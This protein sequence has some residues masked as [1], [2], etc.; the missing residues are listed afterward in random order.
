METDFFILLLNGAEMVETQ[1]LGQAACVD[2]TG[3]GL[4]NAFHHD[5][6]GAIPHRN[7]NAFLVHIHADLFRAVHK[8]ALFIL[9][10]VTE[11]LGM[12]AT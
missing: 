6:S 2:H 10:R 11:Y 4:D 9:R 7:R 1:Q 8:G 5:L 12:R 3:F